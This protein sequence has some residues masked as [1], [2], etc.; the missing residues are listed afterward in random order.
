MNTRLGE[1]L[2]FMAIMAIENGA[3]VKAKKKP[4]EE[5]LEMR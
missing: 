5:I 1:F 2:D 4:M 3:K